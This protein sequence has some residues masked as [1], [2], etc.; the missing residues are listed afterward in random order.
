MSIASA[1]VRPAASARRSCARALPISLVRKARIWRS[2]GR[3]PASQL[4]DVAAH[5]Q[6]VGPLILLFVQLLQIHHRVAILRVEP[7]DFLE[8]LE[9]AV[10]EPSVAEVEREA[11]LDV[12][13]FQL[14]Q[15]GRC[16]SD[17]CSVMARPTCPSRDTDCRESSGSRARP[18][19]LTLVAGS[20]R[21]SP[22]RPGCRRGSSR[23]SM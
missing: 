12:R 16:S 10:D 4:R 14:G 22:G 1:N 19:L 7:H 21:R 13:L 17:W 11:E 18:V 3:R 6:R 23:P 5:A 2:S 8:R 15:S 20:I 9:R